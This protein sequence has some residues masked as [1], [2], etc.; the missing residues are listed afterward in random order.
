M[1]LTSSVEEND[2][3]AEEIFTQKENI[4]KEDS[5]DETNGNN[6]DNHTGNKGTNDKIDAI[7]DSLIFS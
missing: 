7:D 6:H 1:E 2:R 3:Y 4:S 5:I